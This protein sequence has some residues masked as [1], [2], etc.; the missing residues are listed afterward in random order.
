MFEAL[1][2]ILM[3]MNEFLRNVKIRIHSEVRKL[4]PRD[5]KVMFLYYE[6]FN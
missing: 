4:R 5:V 6:R 1:E 2:A 3:K